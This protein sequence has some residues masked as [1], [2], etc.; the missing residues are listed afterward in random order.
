M[1]YL[2]LLWEPEHAIAAAA[3]KRAIISRLEGFELRYDACEI[4]V[5]AHDTNTYALHGNVGV[6]VGRILGG[7]PFDGRDIVQRC[8]GNYVAFVRKNVVRDPSGGMPC[9]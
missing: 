6:V 7:T 5:F 8:W 9:Y 4:A 2:A 1:R 3:L